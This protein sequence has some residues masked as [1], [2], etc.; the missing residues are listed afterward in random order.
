MA[1]DTIRLLIVED[2]E[3]DA[4]LALLELRRNQLACTALRVDTEPQ[5][6]QALQ[7]FAPDLILCDF[8]LPHFDGMTALTLARDRHPDLPFI[9]LS[10]TIGEEIAIESLKRG[11]TDYVLKSNLSR[12]A[13]AVHRALEQGEDR[14][15]SRNAEREL[16][17]IRDRTNSIF[18]S[19][20]DVVWSVSPVRKEI[21][22]I[23]PATREVFG[24]PPEDFLAHPALWFDCVHPDDAPGVREAWKRVVAGDTID[25]VYRILHRNGGVRWI[26][27]RARRVQGNGTHEPRIDGIASDIT[28]RKLQEEKIL[29]LSRIE[30]VLSGVNSAIVRIRNRDELLREACRIAVEDGGFALAWIGLMDE[31]THEPR[32]RASMGED[33]DLA[34]LQRVSLQDNGPGGN[35][36]LDSA[37]RSGTPLVVN[38]LAQ[39]ADEA[40]RAELL[41]RGFAA[42]A[43]L[44]LSMD[45]QTIGSLNLYA[46]ETGFFDQ[47]EM[48]L[49]LDLAGDVS[50][51]LS[52]MAREEKLNYLAYYDVLTGLP[53]RQLFQQRVDQFVSVA[54]QTGGTVALLLLD[55]QR[56]SIVN[57]T[58]GRHA[59]DA[60]LKEVA[61]RLRH[62]L[63]DR[64]PV[65][66]LG[67]DTF[68]IV[69]AGNEQGLDIAH[70]ID[71]TL[72]PA[73]SAPLS[74][75]GH[76]LRPALRCGIAVFPADAGHAEALLR[77]AEAALKKAKSSAD[78]YVFYAPQ[79][80]ARVAEKLDMENRLRVAVA[81]AQF[82]LHYQPKVDVM[83]NRVTGLE[84]LLRWNSPQHGIVLP[85][86]FIPLLEETG[87]ILDVGRSILKQAVADH[88]GWRSAGLTPPRIAINMSSLNLRE[89]GFT[90][91]VQRIASQNGT[92]AL[93]LDLEITESLIMDDM[94]RSIAKLEAIKS[95]GIG[96]AIDDF[97]TGYS[98]LSYIA[99]L[100]VNALKIDRSFIAGMTGSPH[101][102][103][104]VSTIISLAHCLNLKVV[105][106]GVETEEQLKLLRLLRCDEMQG[107]LYSRPLPPDAVR[108]LI[109]S[110]PSP[111]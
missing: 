96:I 33:Q 20:R 99:R 85:D 102:M 1:H 12:L 46:R 110:Q 76:E 40:G 37:F 47:D 88:N 9:F 38:D 43:I 75:A 90:G 4:E 45:H 108:R 106:E 11:A 56:F 16:E 105:A 25:M 79:M 91:E 61:Q 84:A 66:R 82:V 53:N 14:R 68:G 22:Y 15:R 57:T 29:R 94:E 23:N 39:S 97:G 21:I 72:V 8:T 27:N 30:R 44:P 65:A 54:S 35:G 41:R 87:L 104:I 93:Q 101:H 58:L 67:G 36:A 109:A 74:L 89:A 78:T 60:I 3:I 17:N 71:R 103:T 80:N 28:E 31:A 18:N 69:L 7:E 24:R 32:P 70:I 100:P 42:Y 92:G 10:G 48:K 50:F 98:S 83:T 13:P 5:Y 73:V 95:A 26:Q 111:E 51:A 81:G 86:E 77:N 19:L 2:V 49:L 34:Q 55:L 64:H 63:E 62:A 6:L 59:G 107:Y 52:A